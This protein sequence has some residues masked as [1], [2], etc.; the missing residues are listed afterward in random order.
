MPPEGHASGNFPNDVFDSCD[1]GL[2][3]AVAYAI[4]SLHSGN[5][6]ADRLLRGVVDDVCKQAF[7]LSETKKA[8]MPRPTFHHLAATGDSLLVTKKSR[9]L[10]V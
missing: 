3:L 8:S 6:R 4:S 9:R 2:R 10:L 5:N 1:L 7:A